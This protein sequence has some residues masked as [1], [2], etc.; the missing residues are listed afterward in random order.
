MIE[1]HLLSGT[2]IAVNPML[3]MHVMALPN[4]CQLVSANGHKVEVRESFLEVNRAFK[5]W[6]KGG[7]G[8]HSNAS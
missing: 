4:G 3:V 2:Q 8:R 6:A 7:E 5:R 1:L